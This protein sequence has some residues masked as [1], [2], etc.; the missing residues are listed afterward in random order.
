MTNYHAL[1]NGFSKF[2]AENIKAIIFD[3]AHVAPNIIRECFA[4]RINKDHPAWGPLMAIFNE[5]FKSSSFAARFNR[6]I[7]RGKSDR[8]VLFVPGW[9]ILHR[10]NEINQALEDGDITEQNTKYAY[11]HLSDHISQCAV[12]VS[13][14]SI[15][16]SAAAAAG[17]A[18]LKDKVNYWDYQQVLEVHEALEFISDA[19][20]ALDLVPQGF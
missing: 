9:F 5:Y 13:Q 3:D 2:F 15:E 7:N 16:I 18:G 8:G 14:N 17:V 11:A 1:F 20:N 4:L 6:F 12:F 10:R 19:I